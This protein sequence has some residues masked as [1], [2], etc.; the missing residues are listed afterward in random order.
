MLGYWP[1]RQVLG[2][3]HAWERLEKQTKFWS[4]SLKGRYHFVNPG[5]DVVYYNGTSGNGVGICGL[6]LSGSGQEQME[7]SC[8]YGNE[9]MGSIKGEE[10]LGQM[11][12]C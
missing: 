1:L 11:N 10:F 8:E 3:V 6:D 5:V 12:D 7:G 2:L 9:P 4:K